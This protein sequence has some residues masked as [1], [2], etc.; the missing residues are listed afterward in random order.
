M[1]IEIL[2]MEK[3]L[4]K[5]SLI[6]GNKAINKGIE[7]GAL[8]VEADTK[9]NCPVD[10]GLLRASIDHKLNPSTLSATVGSNVEYAVYICRLA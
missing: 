8:R 4:K 6:G 9:R 2:G 7:K 1:G 10:E 5:L 3:L